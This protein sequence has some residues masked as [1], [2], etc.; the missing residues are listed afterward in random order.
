MTMTIAEMLAKMPQ[1]FQPEKAPG[2]DAV[3]QFKFS[4]A[5]AGEWY[6]TFKDDK[7]TVEKGTHASPKM[8]V[9]ADSADLVKI[10]TGEMDGVQAFMQGKIKIAGDLNLAMKMVN[11]FKLT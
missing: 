2:L 1:A 6:A 11:M 5:D 10:L 3:I 8:T 9:S 7:C 4:G